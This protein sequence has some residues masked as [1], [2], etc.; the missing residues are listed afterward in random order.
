MRL[1]TATLKR[2]HPLAFP[3]MATGIVE[4]LISLTD[5]AMVGNIPVNAVES[6]A[7]AGIVSSFLGMLTWV[8]GQTQSSISSLVAQYVG[9]GKIE[10]IRTLPAQAIIISVGASFILVAL[11]LAF[12]EPV[13]RLLNATDSLIGFCISYF[14][15]RVWGVPLTLLTFSIFGTFRG[16]Q[17]TLWPMAIALSGAVINAIA[18]YFLVF[19]WG[20]WIPAMGLDGAGWASLFTQVIMAL[21][22]VVLLGAKT[23]IPLRWIG[24]PH[25]ELKRLIS[26]TLNLF[27]RSV[28]LNTTLIISVRQATVLGPAAVGAHTIALNLWLFAAFLIDGYGTSA[29]I[30][31]G[32]LLGQENYKTLWVLTRKCVY[33]GWGVAAL[34]MLGGWI[35]YQPL[36]HLFSEDMQVLEAFWGVF[37]I[38]LIGMP[39]NAVAFVLDA[40]FKGLGEMKYLRNILLIASFGGFVPFVLLSQYMDWGLSGIWIGFI[41][42]MGI[43]AIALWLKYKAKFLP[44]AQIS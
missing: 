25:P 4:P 42:W 2:I 39:I 7:A 44:L 22:A 12:M 1:D 36:G 13:F 31:G 21:I 10:E 24:P 5:T 35:A 40:L 34:L 29:N 19:G 23:P 18:D 6:L 32:K 8:L 30:L 43:R 17:N 38:V 14:K 27:V 28:A 41:V 9:K 11:G 20:Q 26:M 33:Y 15:I 37:W 16:L 3:A